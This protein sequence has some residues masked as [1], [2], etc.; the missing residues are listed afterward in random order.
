[1]TRMVPLRIEWA[2]ATP[3]CP[4]PFGLHLDG[5]LAW[6]ALQEHLASDS[7]P[8]TYAPVL[9]DL[10]F[11]KHETATGWVW[12]ASLV[13][14]VAVAGSERR[15]MTAKTATAS[16]ATRMQDGR[17]EGK[18]LTKI[19]TVRGPYKNDAFWYT[20]EHAAR[21]V[22]Y[23]VGDPERITPLLDR[24]THLGKRAR[25]DHGRIAPVDGMLAHVEEDAAAAT[26]WRDRNM[27]EPDGDDYLPQ[28]GRLQPP[29]W[30]GEG[31]TMVWR[32]P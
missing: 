8:D 31:Q 12:K 2:L 10:P 13:R 7:M 22:A 11:A 27:P 30:A 5:L 23:C 17:I 21:C 4:P 14:P 15:Y 3:W 18:P 16:F 6:A 25:L 24:I 32:L 1:M 28:F 19:D 9:A 20:I 29:Y 26:K